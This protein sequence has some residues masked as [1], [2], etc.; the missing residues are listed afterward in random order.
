[1]DHATPSRSSPKDHQQQKDDDHLVRFFMQRYAEDL[2]AENPSI[3]PE[4]SAWLQTQSWPG[5]VRELENAVR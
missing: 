4:A 3:Q 2:G 5:N 1:M